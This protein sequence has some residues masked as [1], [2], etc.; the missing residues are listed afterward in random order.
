[1]AKHWH[2]IVQGYRAETDSGGLADV[3]SI[4]VT[5][6][7]EDRPEIDRVSDNRRASTVDREQ[8][9]IEQAQELVKKAHYRVS[10][11]IEHDPDIDPP[12]HR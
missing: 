1:M 10:Q 6:R 9:A 8:Y 4:E 5:V 12:G 2:Y 7:P 11:V 3:A